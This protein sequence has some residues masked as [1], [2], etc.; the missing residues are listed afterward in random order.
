MLPRD[1][2]EKPS[3]AGRIANFLAGVRRRN[4]GRGKSGNRKGKLHVSISF[5]GNYTAR[6][7]GGVTVRLRTLR[8]GSGF[9]GFDETQA[10]GQHGCPLCQ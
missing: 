3:A 2:P 7:M 10:I 5:L 4:G 9:G 6:S 1:H 8:A